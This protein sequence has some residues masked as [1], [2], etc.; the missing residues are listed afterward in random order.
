MSGG[1]P[2][3]SEPLRVPI[4]HLRAD[5]VRLVQSI[6]RGGEIPVSIQRD[7][8]ITGPQY[9]AEV[10]DAIRWVLAANGPAPDEI[11]LDPTLSKGL[12]PVVPPWRPPLPDGRRQATRW[13]RLAAGVVDE[14]LLSVPVYMALAA[15]APAWAAVAIHAMYHALPSAMFG[16]TLGKLWT[17]LRLVDRHSMRTPNVVRIAL[18]WA[19][20]VLPLIA[21]IA[22]GRDVDV[23]TAVS[24]A[25]Y[26][27]IVWRLRGLHDLAAGTAVVER[28][29]A[30]PGL[31]VRQRTTTSVMT[32]GV[33]TR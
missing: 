21:A 7:E 33:P 17:G 4:G 27:P 25:V 15:D 13:R 26:A 23:V 28:S 10:D 20:S 16:W 1:Q 6:L 2:S 9:A 19:V 22:F 8:L 18:R 24:L 12:G 30:G 32:K 11:D 14:V 31:W 3:P 29:P 5:Q